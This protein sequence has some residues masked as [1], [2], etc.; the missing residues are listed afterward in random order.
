VT[1]TEPTSNRPPVAGQAESE[2]PA[3][4]VARSLL[5]CAMALVVAAAV[6][7][8]MTTGPSVQRDGPRISAAADTAIAAATS[9]RLLAIAA[10]PPE[11]TATPGRTHFSG[12]SEAGD[13][14]GFRVW[15]PTALPEQ[16]GLLRVAWQPD[17]FV[18]VPGQR[19]SGVLRCWYWRWEHGAGLLLEQGPGISVSVEG[20]PAG[21]HGVIAL[22]DSQLIIW[23]RGR[24]ALPVDPHTTTMVWSGNELRVGLPAN[25]ARPGWRLISSVLT[26]EELVRVAEG[27][28]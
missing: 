21:E 23:V 14:L 6:L 27:L 16:Y 13:L 12:I 20:A 22:S 28:R 19:P 3:A 10:R 9:T 26:L 25:G 1:N 2:E 11:P 17:S 7:K 8:V 15:Q 5:G 18:T 24:S 4:G